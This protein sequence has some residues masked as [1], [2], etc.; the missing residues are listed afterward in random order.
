MRHDGDEPAC[1]DGDDEPACSTMGMRHT[2]TGIVREPNDPNLTLTL[3]L[4]ALAE[5]GRLMA[6]STTLTLTLTLTVI[7]DNSR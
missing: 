6:I 5:F 3:T 2:V 1:H 7:S 4:Q